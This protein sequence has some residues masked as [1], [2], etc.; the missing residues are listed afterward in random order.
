[1][2][3]AGLPNRVFITGA[4]GFLGRAL[5]VHL[6]ERGVEV[7]GMDLVADPAHGV[8]EGDLC[9]PEDW[10]QA[11]VGADIL[12][13]TAAAVSNTIAYE[14]AWKTNVVATRK[15]IESAIRGGVGRFVHISSVAAFG[16]NYCD[17]V[18]ETAPVKPVGHPYIDT[19]IAS[20]HVALSAH[21][22]G[23]MDVTIVRPGDV[24]GPRSRP[25]VLL[26]LEMIGA[27]RFLLPAHGE[28]IFTPVYIDDIVEG[29][30][31][32]AIRPAGSGQIFTLD[33]G[34][35][36]RCR[37]FFGYHCRF[38]GKAG[39]PRTMSTAAAN[40]LADTVG[41]VERRMGIPSELGRNTMGM[42]CRPG[43]YSIEKARR[44]L[45]Y[46][47]KVTLEEGMARVRD[48]LVSEE[49]IPAHAM[50]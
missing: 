30:L 48:W 16:F 23:E 7:A 40:L 4:S 9:R 27:G 33:G 29:I 8:I 42:F 1:M 18:D 45:G 21:G 49:R 37:D 17:G 15:L 11:V 41:W 6:R 14:L 50:G 44:L 10:E 5:M 28:G 38:L 20:E 12:I 36:V 47:P 26:P 32:A 24:Y 31:L 39:G 22:A 43:G 34:E 3:N 2:E 46:A 35:Q 13:H 25:W 19:K